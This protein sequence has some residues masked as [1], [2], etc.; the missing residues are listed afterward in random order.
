MINNIS[1]QNVNI[2]TNSPQNTVHTSVTP[3]NNRYETTPVQDI[4]D[5]NTEEILKAQKENYIKNSPLLNTYDK[6]S[7]EDIYKYSHNAINVLELVDIEGLKEIENI[8]Q[9]VYDNTPHYWNDKVNPHAL[10]N[11]VDL[12]YYNQKVFE[13][14]INS[15]PI[16]NVFMDDFR[17]NACIKDLNIAAA[18]EIEKGAADPIIMDFVINSDDFYKDSKKINELS[19]RLSQNKTTGDITVYR[20]DRHVGMFSEIPINNSFLTKKI[21]LSNFINQLSTRNEKIGEFN[22]EYNSHTGQISLYNY[23]KNKKE[24][25]LSDAMLMMKYMD[26]HSQNEILELI[27]NAK[28]EDDGRF[29]STTLSPK[30]AE[31]WIGSCYNNER[32]NEAKIMSKIN[33]KENCE[34]VYVQGEDSTNGQCE[35]IVNNKPKITTI[36]NITYDKEKNTF[37]LEYDLEMIS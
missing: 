1:R 23:I 2:K 19:A 12:Y 9:R 28:V 13:Y 16:K 4:V 20:G 36:K 18:K 27:K 35:F 11:F 17:S 34:G 15:E 37:N 3:Y 33:I 24:L 29:K 30:F 14:C 22:K 21:K 8:C 10:K 31:Q 6:E 32:K 5:I 25:S 7:K 26:K